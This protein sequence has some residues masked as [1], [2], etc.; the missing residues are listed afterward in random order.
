MLTRGWKQKSL[1]QQSGVVLILALLI[2]ALVTTIAV[3]VSWRFNLSVVRN[4]NRWHGS[5]ARV[6]LEAAEQFAL[7]GLREDLKNGQV[8]SLMEQWAQPVNS[9]SPLGM[10]S[11]IMEDAHGRLNLNLMIAEKQ[12]TGDNKPRK[13]RLE[14]L[15]IQQRMFIRLLQLIPLEEG[16][17]DET[18]AM[19]I[20]D[21]IED[22]I[23]QGNEPI[24]TGGAESS[25]YENLDPPIFITNNEMSSVSELLLVKGMTPEIFKQV[26]QYVIA[27]PGYVAEQTGKQP[28]L[29]NINTLRPELLRC[30]NDPMLLEPLDEAAFGALKL[31][32]DSA[33][34][35]DPLQPGFRS[36]DEFINHPEIKAVWQNPP[37]KAEDFVVSSN[38][39]LLT[40]QASIEDLTTGAGDENRVVRGGKSLLVRPSNGPPRV[41][42]RSDAGF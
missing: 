34:A 36:V 20:V 8:D 14:L 29:M 27:L 30:L 42:R 10:I 1:K 16:P 26:E 17:L 12:P 33:N 4:A 25:Y 5:Q 22:W 40:A 23:D 35:E 38:Y 28:V 15:S 3:S 9:P 2:V 24:G 31:I 11:G 19:E 37:F 13:S 18:R 7:W 39:F 32:R 21:A 6:H 41:V